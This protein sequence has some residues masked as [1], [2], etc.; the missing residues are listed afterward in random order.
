MKSPQTNKMLSRVW[1]FHGKYWSIRMFFVIFGRKR[2]YPIATTM[3]QG[4]ALPYFDLRFSQSGNL[5]PPRCAFPQ[6]CAHRL[7]LYL[8]WKFITLTTSK[9]LPYLA[10]TVLVKPRSQNACS[11]MLVLSHVAVVSLRRIPFPTTSQSNKNMATPFLPLHFMWNG[12]RRSSTSSTAQDL[13]T[14]WAQRWQHS[15]WPTL[16]S[17]SSMVLSVLK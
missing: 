13:T 4:L 12:T 10:T 9:T 11:I 5:Y 6:V 16:L 17:F 8:A 7:N 15:M 2:S 1:N 14:S 3:K